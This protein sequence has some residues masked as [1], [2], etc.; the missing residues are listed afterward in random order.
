M[1]RVVRVVKIQ[2]PRESKCRRP[3]AADHF[4]NRLRVKG[5]D[6]GR[7]TQFGLL[8]WW[9]T[10]DGATRCPCRY[11]ASLP[12]APGGHARAAYRPSWCRWRTSRR[13]TDDL[14]GALHASAKILP[15]PRGG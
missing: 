6:A 13:A 2:V 5:V 15:K 9:A 1:A 10:I 12:T 3:R 14:G 7:L 4:G 11:R 8:H